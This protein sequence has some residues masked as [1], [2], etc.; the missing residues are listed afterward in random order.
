MNHMYGSRV[1][2]RSQ[3]SVPKDRYYITETPQTSQNKKTCSEIKDKCSL[4]PAAR[5]AD[6]SQ[7]KWHLEVVLKWLQ[8]GTHTAILWMFSTMY[9]LMAH[10]SMFL[11]GVPTHVALIRSFSTVNTAKESQTAPISK[12]FVTHIAMVWTFSTMHMLMHCERTHLPN[13]CVTHWY[14]RFPLRNW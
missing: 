14:G 5:Y 10:E 1:L 3:P 11:T 6:H 7:K 2:L 8:F 12:R 4:Q 9:T 13:E